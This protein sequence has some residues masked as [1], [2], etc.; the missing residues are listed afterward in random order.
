MSTYLS[1]HDLTIETKD[2]VDIGVVALG[3]EQAILRLP[4]IHNAGSVAVSSFRHTPEAVQIL[5]RLKGRNGKFVEDKL[6]DLGRNRL[7]FCIEKLKM[8]GILAVTA[9]LDHSENIYDYPLPEAD[10][11][12]TVMFPVTGESGLDKSLMSALLSL[13]TGYPIANFESRSQ[14][15]ANAYIEYLRKKV[16]GNP[17]F[18]QARNL[19]AQMRSEITEGEVATQTSSPQPNQGVK[20]MGEMLDTALNYFRHN[21]SRPAVMVCDMPGEPKAVRE[22]TG[23]IS[24]YKREHTVYE[25]MSRASFE[26][27]RLLSTHKMVDAQMDRKLAW[28]INE[29]INKDL[30]KWR[31][32]WNKF[33]TAIKDH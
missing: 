9:A 33:A 11:A 8:P 4:D 25:F 26:S 27:P 16:D 31:R 23:E 20:T 24:G 21:S 6:T 22:S 5:N 1:E 2:G 17:G 13:Q 3:T 32:T 15:S 19:V 18:S 29:I 10:T 7:I 30:D 14:F 12:P 28:V